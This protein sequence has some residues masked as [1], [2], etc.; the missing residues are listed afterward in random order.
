MKDYALIDNTIGAFPSVQAQNAT[1][2]GT[3][4]GTPI[5]KEVIDDLWGARQALMTEAGLTP[6]GVTE[7]SGASQ[8]LTALDAI[9][10]AR[11]SSF[12]QVS[13]QSIEIIPPSAGFTEDSNKWYRQFYNISDGPYWSGAV[14][15]YLIAFPFDT[16]A[17]TKITTGSFL[18]FKDASRA[19]NNRMSLGLYYVNVS[20]SLPSSPVLVGSLVWD[21]GNAGYEMLT[22]N[23]NHDLM[24]AANQYMWVLSSGIGSGATDCIWWGVHLVERLLCGARYNTP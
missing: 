1:G 8:V 4:D 7:A 10:A 11:L 5:I 23:P 13:A 14:G 3:T 20:S 17:I 6:N 18:I 15:G 9:I 21:D 12:R 24:P 16:S 19:G 2:P 22:V